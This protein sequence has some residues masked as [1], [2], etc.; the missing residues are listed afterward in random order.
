VGI[1]S[2]G[3]LDHGK[4]FVVRTRDMWLAHGYAVVIPDALDAR[5]MCGLRSS[6][7]YAQVIQDLVV[8]AHTE[9]PGPVFLL[10]TSQGS[11]AAMNGAAHLSTKQIAGVVLTESVSRQS[12]SGETVFDASPERVTVPA[13]VV[14]NRDSRCRVAPAQDAS[15]IAAA[16]KHAPEV[17]V[18]YVRGGVTRS[19]DCGSQSPHGYWGINSAVVDAMR[20]GWIP[21]L[22]LLQAAHEVSPTFSTSP[23]ADQAPSRHD[24]RR[25]TRARGSVRLRSR[26]RTAGPIAKVVK[27][28]SPRGVVLS[29]MC[30]TAAVG[31]QGDVLA[32]RKPRLGK[33][34]LPRYHACQPV[35]R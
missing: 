26:N 7:D 15:R 13:L 11:I 22:K 17:K 29:A 2:N 35:S 24:F 1:D 18:L 33:P 34:R 23:D 4:N 5:N 12:K 9:A 20:L 32:N 3:D 10:G 27:A 16:M 6:S 30:F 31:E 25:S 28:D 14:A 21:V 8:F 19:S